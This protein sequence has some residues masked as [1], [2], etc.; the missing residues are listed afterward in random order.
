M[1]AERLQEAKPKGSDVKRKKN[2]RSGVPKNGGRDS[3][4]RNTREEQLVKQALAL[5]SQGG[6]RETSLQDIADKLGITRPLFYYYFDSKEDLLWRLIGHV[7]DELLE[8]ARPIANGDGGPEQRLRKLLEA[9]AE[10]LLSNLDTFRVYFAERHLVE[11]KRN[12]QLKRGEDEYLGLFATV[13]GEGQRA[14]IFRRENRRVLALIATGAVNSLM[15]WF[16]P[17]GIM[18]GE[19]IGVLS[20]DIAVRGLKPS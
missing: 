9:H 11:G 14:G 19:D 1:S 12:R 15:R 4:L 18:N 20:A 16:E 5:F 8:H 6:F 7:G 17:D 13:I 10:T 3:N 2:G